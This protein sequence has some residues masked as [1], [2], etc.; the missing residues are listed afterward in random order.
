[1]MREREPSWVGEESNSLKSDAIRE[2]R[3]FCR[4]LPDL[5]YPA[6]WFIIVTLWL[7]ARIRRSVG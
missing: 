6:G 7:D 2:F 3:R 5:Y 4:L 1:M